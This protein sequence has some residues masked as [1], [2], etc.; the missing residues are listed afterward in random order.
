MKRYLTAIVLGLTATSAIAA[1]DKTGW[2]I[3]VAAAF[4]EYKFDSNQLDDSSAGFK[5]F[6]GYRFNQWLGVEGAYHNFG[7]FE[8]DTTPAVTGGDAIVQIDGLSLA[9][10][11]FLPLGGEDFELYGKAGFYSFN[12]DAFR[13]APPLSDSN[14]SDGLHLGAGARFFISDQFAVRSEGDWF[15]I[16]NGD[17]WSLNLGFEYQFGR[18]AK[19]AAPVV[20]AAP[21]AAVVAA[22][23]P[24]P[25]PVDSDGDGV[26]EGSDQCPG[27]PA[28]A[29][30][31]AQGCEEQLVL[32]G[33]NFST[34]SAT[35]T[36]QDL[37][38]LDS[39]ADTLAKRP[40]FSV[41]VRGHTDDAGSEASNLDLSQR[42][43]ESV[44][45]YLVSNGISPEKLTA[46]G[47]GETDPIASNETA[48]GRAQNRRVTLEFSKR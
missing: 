29:K 9:G 20:M 47:K 3:G 36:P 31:D 42:R 45:D 37:L 26:V 38:L 34:G 10:L 2:N 16:D 48:D 25:A 5:L 35:L 23:A 14:S 12:Q 4:G 24:P 21:V 40:A 11:F 19:V 7:D 41:E 33:V 43:A 8:E 30:V 1:D 27:T 17:L 22:P 18:P 44:R 32:R 6:A 46:V 28:G 15:N 39:V 13:D